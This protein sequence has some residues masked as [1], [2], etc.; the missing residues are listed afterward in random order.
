MKWKGDERL[1]QPRIHSSRIRELHQVREK[2]GRPM[3]VLIDEA[4]YLY[5]RLQALPEAERDEIWQKF[6]QNLVR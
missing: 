1:Y 5:T 2:D 6:L 3:T 4:L